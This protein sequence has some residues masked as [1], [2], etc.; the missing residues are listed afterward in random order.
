MSQTILIDRI[1]QCRGITA[2]LLTHK[3]LAM[4]VE[5]VSLCRT[6]QLG[7]I[8]LCTTG[9]DV[10]LFDIATLGQD[11]F[12]AGGLKRV[13]ESESIC[14]VIFDGR[15]DADAL[16]HRHWVSLRRA[17]DLQIH[18]ALRYSSEGDRYV[19]GLQK[20]LD[21]S[22][23]VPYT[24]KARV[25][26]VKG[27]GKRMFARDLG[28]RPEVWLERPLPQALIDYA[29]SDVR[30]L[31]GIK[32]A[33]SGA[34]TGLVFR[35]TK[36]R[37]QG[38]ISAAAPA[39]GDHQSLRDFTLGSHAKY[40]GRSAAVVARKAVMR[41]NWDDDEPDYDETDYDDEPDCDDEPDYD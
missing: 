11:A 38:A 18:H 12:E 22:G 39:R 32:E 41:T 2:Q 37:L 8:Q 20:C 16:Y 19:K 3:E 33:W 24:D 15:A 21:N 28:G 29:A 5:G 1:Q 25:Q 40:L 13:L 4:D 26:R 31:L 34:T 9:G 35:V 17:Y 27:D 14:K 30:Y 10:W 7:L 36:D 23:V 6:G